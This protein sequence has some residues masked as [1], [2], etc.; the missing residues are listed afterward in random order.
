LSS[1]L[2]DWS[3]ILNTRK[4]NVS[5]TGSVSVLR[6]A[7]GDILCWILTMDKVQ[8]ASNSE[9]NTPSSEPFRFYSSH[10]FSSILQTTYDVFAYPLRYLLVSQAEHRWFTLCHLYLSSNINGPGDMFVI[11]SSTIVVT[12]SECGQLSNKSTIPKERVPWDTN[13]ASEEWSLLGWNAVCLLY[14]F[15]T[16][17][18]F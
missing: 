12:V 15:A 4:H 7:D 1:G 3:W 5:E 6:C 10:V 9:C 2:C 13:K 14:F 17:V 18:G 11:I 8:N 16:C